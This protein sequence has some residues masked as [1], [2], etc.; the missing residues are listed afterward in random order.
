M[1]TIVS[2]DPAMAKMAELK[3]GS[4]F[5]GPR[6]CVCK[7]K[8]QQ[9]KLALENVERQAFEAYLP[10]AA[11]EVR[12]K[13][14][15]TMV[16]SRPFIPSYLFVRIDLSDGRWRKLYNT[17]GLTGVLGGEARPSLMND[18]A[19][20]MVEDIRAREEDGFIRITPPD[21]TCTFRPGDKVTWAR[22]MEC[23][24]HDVVDARRARI[25]VTLLGTDS[26]QTVDLAALT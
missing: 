11:I 16:V 6:W 3:S 17:R 18:R 1:K 2:G 19:A 7:T 4:P 5:S 14:Q 9:E 26:L 12:R 10:M 15:P 20:A 8:A 24:F 21:P 13:G 25:I 23:V 22:A